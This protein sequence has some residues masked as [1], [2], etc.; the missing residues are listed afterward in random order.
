MFL[1]AITFFFELGVEI[2][3]LEDEIFQENLHN[4]S[5]ESFEESD[6]NLKNILRRR[7]I[8]TNLKSSFSGSRRRKKNNH[9]SE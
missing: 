2:H 7:N 9:K 4:E 5:N 1:E 8:F 6:A 3:S